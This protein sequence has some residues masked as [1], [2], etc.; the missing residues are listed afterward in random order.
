VITWKDFVLDEILGA[1]LTD[2]EGSC[3][4]SGSNLTEESRTSVQETRQ[5]QRPARMV[6]E[7]GLDF[8]QAGMD[9]GRAQTSCVQPGGE[10]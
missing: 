10:E 3:T 7:S 8:V 2:S 9:A 5:G 4:G 1:V 6:G